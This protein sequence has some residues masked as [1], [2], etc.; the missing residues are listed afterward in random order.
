VPAVALQPPPD[1][2]LSPEPPP[3]LL[4]L[5][6]VLPEL[7]V[8]LLAVLPE[9]LLVV[10]PELLPLLDDVLPLLLVEVPLLLPLLD[11]LPLLLVLLPLLLPLLLLLAVASDVVASPPEPASEPEEEPPAS[12]GT[13]KEQYGAMHVA[14]CPM[15]LHSLSWVHHPELAAPVAATH[16]CGFVDHVQMSVPQAVPFA[17]QS[18]STLHIVCA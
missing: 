18:V 5:L 14:P 10:V 2:L 17:V 13:V 4:P 6:L 9:L 11:V 1:E 15:H 8:L 3:E 7:P 16:E 12:G